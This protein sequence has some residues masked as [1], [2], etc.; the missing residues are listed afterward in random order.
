MI[1]TAP[2]RMTP[3]VAV[4][5][6][7]KMQQMP[8]SYD[9]LAN[10]SGL[11]KSSVARWIRTMRAAGFAHIACYGNDSVGRP[12]VPLWGW[13]N[14]PDMQRPGPRRTAAER[15]RELRNKQGETT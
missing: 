3:L 4:V 7:T 11:P 2:K 1:Y 9:E 14:K 6:Q 8:R 10:I 13:G 12:F 5:L 15:M